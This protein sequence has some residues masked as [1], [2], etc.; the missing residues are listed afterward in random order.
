MGKVLLVDDDPAVLRLVSRE[1]EKAGI[2]SVCAADGAAALRAIA[3]EV[4]VAIVLDLLLPDTSGKDLLVT[5]RRTHPGVPVV[6]L[7]VQDAVDDVVECMRLGAVDFIHKPFE[8]ARLVAS[9]RN[10][11]TQGS[12][13]RRVETL[14]DELRGKDGFDAFL[15]RSGPMLRV[16]ELLQRAAGSDVT[17]LLTGESGTGKEVAARAIHAEGPRRT[18]PFVALNCG[19]I[20]EGLLESELFGHEKGAFTG[21]V[22]MRRG[23]F[24]VAEGGTLLLDEVGE[25]RTDLQ[26][27]LLRVLQER[28]VRRVGASADRPID[29]R[30]IAATNRDL[31]EAVR[32]GRF[33]EDLF[34]RVAVFPIPLPPL[35]AREGDVDLLAATFLARFAARHRRPAREFSSAAGDA[36]RRWTWPGNVRELENAVERAVIL[37]DGPSI[38]IESLPDVVSGLHPASTTTTPGFRDL[39]ASAAAPAR[40][41]DIVPIAE[42]ERRAILAALEA[43]GWN[44]LEAAGRL[45]IGRATIYRRLESYGLR[46]RLAAVPEEDR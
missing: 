21:A 31:G 6:M 22:A 23:C 15:G 2:Q 8:Q 46:Q 16:R 26:V 42:I 19:A 27:R 34:Y 1:L 43:T 20:P 44:I 7:T 9:V 12:L 40:P 28:C 14:A 30:V 17:V 39:S 38:G 18:G 3:E 10:A 41:E 11:A 35:R 33:R 32:E 25:L 45:G 29:V 24:E 37:E 5:F 13:R 36:L 4:P